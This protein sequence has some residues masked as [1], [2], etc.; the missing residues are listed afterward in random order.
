[1]ENPVKMGDLGVPSF[2]ETPLYDER[3]FQIERV[4]SDV[5]R[6]LVRKSR[7]IPIPPRDFVCLWLISGVGDSKQR[8]GANKDFYKHIGNKKC[9]IKETHRNP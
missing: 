8:R 7:H 2:K 5:V 9:D 6:V 4:L 1:M 3:L